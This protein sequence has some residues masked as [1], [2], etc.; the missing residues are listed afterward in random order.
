MQKAHNAAKND[1][2]HN[3]PDTSSPIT[4]TELNRIETSIDTI[5]DRVVTFDTTKANQSDM[6][7]AVKSVTYTE[8]T[9]T[10]RITFFNNNFIDI[11]TD[12]EKV[13]INFNFDDDPT[14]QHYQQL[15]IE[16]DDGTYKYI[17]LS[18]LI[19]QFEFLSTATIQAVVAQDGK[20]SFNIING[21]VTEDKLQPNFLADCRNAKNSAEAAATTSISSKEDAEAWAVG[22]RNGADVPSTDGT[23]HNNAKYWAGQARAI[24]GNKV[25]Q[26]NGRTGDVYPA[27]GDYT[28]DQIAATGSTGQ[29]PTLG[30]N[31]KLAMQTPKT[32]NPFKLGIAWGV[33][34]TAAATTRKEVTMTT[35][36]ET[37][38]L[39]NGCI[40]TITFQNEVKAG[41]TLK[42][43][44]VPDFPIYYNG[45]AIINN[46]IT[47]GSTALIQ[48]QTGSSIQPK[49][50]VLAVDKKIPNELMLGPV[51]AGIGDADV[52]LTNALL[53]STYL[54]DVYEE[55]T[56]G[57]IVPY[58]SAV[59]TSGQVVIT[60]D[61]PLTEATTFRA[62][63]RKI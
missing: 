27:D 1:F 44:N 2:W 43:D 61:Y 22:K 25:D 60:F 49:F 26:F 55:N 23:F 7:Q 35:A 6:L 16:L 13:A 56:S 3:R 54:I 5:D 38:S 45:S 62:I 8:S 51:T 18:S 10:F 19:T 63:A 30:S 12:L 20:V 14:S 36:I 52:T 40:F 46:I 48:Y 50:V 34:T 31:G 29:V 21:S 53:D 17:D 24:V 42:I 32:Y 41:D 39:L 9:G 28:I 4:E 37:F 58:V 33:C 11:N 59:V 15:V 57:T 47:A